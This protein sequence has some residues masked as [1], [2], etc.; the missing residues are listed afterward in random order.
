M[1]ANRYVSIKVGAFKG[2]FYTL[3][4]LTFVKDE[5]YGDKYTFPGGRYDEYIQGLIDVVYD[6]KK[7]VILETTKIDIKEPSKYSI[8]TEC[9]VSKDK[10]RNNILIKESIVDIEYILEENKIQFKKYKKLEEYE[11]KYIDDETKKILVLDSII[12]FRYYTPV[13]IFESGRRER[14]DMYIFQLETA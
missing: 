13:Y 6:T 4:Q 1:S 3:D 11:L 7:H 2:K 9:L 8:G 10:Y 12:E 5:F 14:F